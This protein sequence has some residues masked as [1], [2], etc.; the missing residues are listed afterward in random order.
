MDAA[1]TLADVASAYLLNAQ[2][3][4]DLEAASA[5]ERAALEQLRIVDRTKTEFL[6]T[7]IHEL[8]TPMTSITG[9]TEM[10]QD[11]RSGELSDT[12]HEWST[13]STATATGSPR[14]PTTCWSWPG[15]RRARSARAHRRRPPRGGRGGPVG[16]AGAHRRPAP[17]RDLRACPPTPVLVDGDARDLERLVTNLLTNAVK[18]TKDGGWVRCTLS[19]DGSRRASRSAT[20]ASA[21]PRPTRPTC[22]PGSSASSTAQEQAISGSGLGLNIVQSIAHNHGGTVSVTSEPGHGA[23]FVVELPLLA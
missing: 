20:T 7:V 21:S 2:A 19:T 17:G 13:P 4:V 1:Q 23:T 10:L 18:F 11:G 8:R 12:Q 15:S 14:W 9:Y 16:P 5:T 6:T 3:R 22:S